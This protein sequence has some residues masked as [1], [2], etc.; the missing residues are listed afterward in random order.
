MTAEEDGNL[1]DR[2][3]RSESHISAAVLANVEQVR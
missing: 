1:A 2:A 3:S